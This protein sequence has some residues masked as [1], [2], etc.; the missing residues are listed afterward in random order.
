V[1]F[2]TADIGWKRIVRLRCFGAKLVV[3]DSP[4]WKMRPPYSIVVAAIIATA[5]AATAAEQ[6]PHPPKPYE[7]VAINLPPAWGDAG[8]DAFRA[9]LAAVAKRRIYGELAPLVDAQGFFWHRDFAR[10]FD[11]RRPAVDNLAAA[12]QL[13]QRDG[14]GWQMLAAFAA[15]ISAE[16]LV[17]R[18]GTVCAPAHPGYDGVAYAKLLATTY[19]R[20]VEWA[21][22]RADGTPVYAAPEAGAAIVARLGLYFVRLLGFEGPNNEP[23]RLRSQW[24]RVVTPAGT[25]GYVAPN[26][27]TSV[28]AERLCYRN[29]ALGA[30]WIAGFIGAGN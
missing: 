5:S 28:A 14:A 23:S 27:L 6:S 8:F 7:P 24:A 20:D 19:T 16:P 3:R 18:A 9:E 15:E 12:I 21:Y 13:E 2:S 30:W 22:P 1:G 10:R 11:L 25:L 29:D 26:V 17:S 4:A